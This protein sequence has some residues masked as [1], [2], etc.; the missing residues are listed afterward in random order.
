ME[1]KKFSFFKRLKTSIFDFD[2]YQD[3]AAEKVSRTIAYIAILMLIFSIIISLIYTFEIIQLI[4][5]SKNYI[6]T[7]IAEIKYESNTLD[8]IPVNGEETIRID[9]ND[10]ISAKVLINTRNR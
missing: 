5:N 3:L 1:K 9:I 2:G 6:N 7:N 4:N 10:F 8:V